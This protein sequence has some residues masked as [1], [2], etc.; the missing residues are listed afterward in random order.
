V[1]H[2]HRDFFVD[3]G[4]DHASLAI[5]AVASMARRRANCWPKPAHRATAAARLTVLSSSTKSGVG[6]HPLRNHV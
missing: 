5:R 3:D 4:K 6:K 2:A 1:L